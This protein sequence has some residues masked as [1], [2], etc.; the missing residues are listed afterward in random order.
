VSGVPGL[1]PFIQIVGF[2]IA[3]AAA[4]VWL[5]SSL[6]KQRHEELENLAETRGHRVA[7]LEH[8]VQELHDQV[9]ELRGEVRAI[10]D[11]K[12]EEI[13]DAVVAKLADL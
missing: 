11:L 9:A 7:D 4:A 3:V 12:A 1:E 5:K 13:A 6:V 2:A 8:R 10:Q